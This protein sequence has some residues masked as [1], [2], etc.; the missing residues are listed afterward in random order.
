MRRQLSS[1]F[2][3]GKVPP[4]TYPSLHAITFLLRHP[5]GIYPLECPFHRYV[6]ALWV[7][8][9]STFLVPDAPWQH[10]SPLQASEPPMDLP[11]GDINSTFLHH[12]TPFPSPASPFQFLQQELDNQTKEEHLDGHPSHLGSDIW[13]TPPSRTNPASTSDI[14]QQLIQAL[15]LVGQNS[16]SIPLPTPPAPPALPAPTNTCIRAPDTFNGSNPDDL[17]PFLL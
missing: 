6:R 12:D 17:W 16:T 1:H 2:C 15:M 11:V 14:L 4:C 5:A 3:S 8:R 10:P 9:H 7:L 13:S